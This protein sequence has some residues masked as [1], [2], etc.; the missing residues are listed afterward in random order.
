MVV[1]VEKERRRVKLLGLR[2]WGGGSAEGGGY[3]GGD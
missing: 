3:G 2:G 1:E